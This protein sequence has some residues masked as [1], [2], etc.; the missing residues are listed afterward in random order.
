MDVIEVKK[1]YRYIL[2]K[3][4]PKYLDRKVF[5]LNCY[6]QNKEKEKDYITC[7]FSEEKDVKTYLFSK[8]YNKF[9]KVDLEKLQE[10]QK[11]GL[12]FGARIG[13]NGA[14]KLEKHLEKYNQSQ[15]NKEQTQMEIN[16]I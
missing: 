9:L 8:K 6:R 11:D 2:K 7:I 3:I 1:Y 5:L 14:R 13:E 16:D 4:I 10:L 12:K 15:M